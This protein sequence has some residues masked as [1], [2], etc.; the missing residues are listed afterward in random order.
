MS[1]SSEQS[2]KGPNSRKHSNPHLDKMLAAY[3]TTATAVGVALLAA[4]Q[5]ADAKI[6]YTKINVAAHGS[7]LLDLNNDGVP[8]F[9]I[10]F[11]SCGGSGTNLWIE[12][13][14]SRYLHAGGNAIR[15]QAASPGSAAALLKGALIGP[16]RPFTN[17]PYGYGAWMAWFAPYSSGGP[18]LNVTNRYL[19]LKFLIHGQVHYGWA[20]LTKVGLWNF[21]VTGYAYETTVGKSL[22]AGQ[23]TETAADEADDTASLTM[24]ATRG[25]SLGML[26]RGAEAMAVWRKKDQIA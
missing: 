14:S 10:R 16:N 3:A 5:P 20:R 24:P 4:V 1:N 2:T 18:W 26:A 13:S 12:V 25:P 8:D 21:T 7:Y 17:P 15:V 9:N 6:I 22:Q 11:C 19:G 23:T